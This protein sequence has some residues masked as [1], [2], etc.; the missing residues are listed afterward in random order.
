MQKNSENSTVSDIIVYKY[1]SN[2]ALNVIFG[3][4]QLSSLNFARSVLEL[5]SSKPFTMFTLVCVYNV[6][7]VIVELCNQEVMLS[8][9]IVLLCM[10]K[11]STSQSRH[12]LVVYYNII[13]RAHYRD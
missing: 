2:L 6:V 10:N 9:V 1:A 12:F 3:S 8:Y 11:M 7:T 5:D 4:K 13:Y